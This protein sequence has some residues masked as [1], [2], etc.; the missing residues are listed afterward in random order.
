MNDN[1][2]QLL[3]PYQQ[4]AKEWKVKL[5]GMRKEFQVRG[6]HSPI[7]FVTSRIKSIPSIEEKMERRHISVDRLTEDMEDLCG[8]RIMCPFLD[9]VYEVVQLLRRRNDVE[10]VSERDYV[11]NE[12]ESGYR[13]YHI[14]FRYPLQMLAGERTIL[15]EIQVRTLAMNF[16]ATLE[17]SLNYKHS[18]DFPADVHKRLQDASETAFRLDEEMSQIHHELSATEADE[19]QDHKGEQ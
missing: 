19:D 13:S 17:H 11:N 1:W 9:D 8:L 4:A 7:E 3:F 2:D 15:V 5:R 10:I 14:V 16:W 6:E 12:K 18:G